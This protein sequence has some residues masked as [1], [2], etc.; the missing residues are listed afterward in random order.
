MG[1]EPSWLIE[2]YRCVDEYQAQ[3]ANKDRCNTLNICTQDS[4]CTQAD[5][6]KEVQQEASNDNN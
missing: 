6:K 3:Y 4:N 1:C 2:F 5:N